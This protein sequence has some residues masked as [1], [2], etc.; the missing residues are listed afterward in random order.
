MAEKQVN[1]AHNSLGQFTQIVRY[2][3]LSGT[4]ADE[5]ATSV[6][7]YDAAHRL[8]GLS[9]NRGWPAAFYALQLE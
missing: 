8:V 9:H 5:V 3:A 6:Y 7:T 2:R 1:M 4:P